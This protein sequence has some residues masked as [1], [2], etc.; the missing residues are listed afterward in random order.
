MGES[1]RSRRAL[2]CGARECLCFE[3][4]GRAVVE[5]LVQAGV[6]EPADPLEDR[7]LELGAGLPDAVGDQLGLE[8]ID[9]ALGERVDA[10]Y[11]CSSSASS[12]GVLVAREGGWW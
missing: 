1:R 7:E 6:V 8:G 10:P 9:K 2:V 4:G 5:R 12:R 11:L 3:L